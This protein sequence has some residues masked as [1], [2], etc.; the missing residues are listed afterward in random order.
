M[1]LRNNKVNDEQVYHTVI[2]RERIRRARGP[3]SPIQ[4]NTKGE[5]GALRK[6]AS[7]SYVQS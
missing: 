6:V 2:A 7:G 4:T 1:L 3:R 5:P